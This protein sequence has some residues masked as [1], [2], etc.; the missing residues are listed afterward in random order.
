MKLP[1]LTFLSLLCLRFIVI[2]AISFLLGLMAS[3]KALPTSFMRVGS[4]KAID[5]VVNNG[6]S[7]CS[8]SL[9]MC[10]NLM[11]MDVI[12]PSSSEFT[13]QWT[14]LIISLPP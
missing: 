10:L 2:L 7:S 14:I 4:Q 13:A 6:Y 5:I 12:L 11:S 3:L 9:G 8:F 1:I